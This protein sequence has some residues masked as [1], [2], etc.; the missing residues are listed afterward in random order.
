MVGFTF[1]LTA[2]VVFPAMMMK[3]WLWTVYMLVIMAVG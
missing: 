1:P 2:V 3:S